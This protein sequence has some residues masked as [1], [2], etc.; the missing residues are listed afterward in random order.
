MAM[1]ATDK[2][3]LERIEDRFTYHVPAGDQAERYRQLRESAK[4]F[5]RLIIELCP[6]SG[7]R[8]HALTQLQSVVMF[9]NA[10]IAT[11]GHEPAA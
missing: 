3:L 2:Q 1:S 10:S 5:A 6:E 9:A 8:T 11:H 7:E 4:H